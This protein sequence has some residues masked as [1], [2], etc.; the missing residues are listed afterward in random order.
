M[1][2]RQAVLG[3][4]CICAIKYLDLTDPSTIFY[5]RSAYAC[6]SLMVLLTLGILYMKIQSADDKHEITVT[7]AELNPPPAFAAAL[8]AP[9]PEDANEPQK[10][11]HK[12]YDLLKL[13]ALLKQTLT[14]MCITVGLHVWKG[15]MP[16]LVLQSVLGMATLLSNELCSIHLF[17]QTVKSNPALKRPFKPKSMFDSLKKEMAQT[18]NNDNKPPRK[19]KK[20]ENMKKTR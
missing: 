8:G 10:M 2:Y 3:I 13:Q 15:F 20:A 11:T 5:A 16:P 19:N 14:T 1:D 6:G 17:G 18:M 4:F 9:Q 7:G 12:E